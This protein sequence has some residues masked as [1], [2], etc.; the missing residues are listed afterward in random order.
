MIYKVNFTPMSQ[1]PDALGAV[2]DLFELHKELS[3]KLDAL[4]AHLGIEFEWTNPKDGEFV[5]KKGKK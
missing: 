1:A 4:I 5:V 3:K 2:G